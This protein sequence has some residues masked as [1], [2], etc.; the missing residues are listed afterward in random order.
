MQLTHF[1]HSCVLVDGVGDSRLLFDPGT[2]STGFEQLTGLDGVLVTHSHADHL[3][4]ARWPA[5][6]AANP[7]CAVLADSAGAAALIDAGHR[8]QAPA[9]GTHVVAGASIEVLP[10]AHETIHPEVPNPPNN[11]YLVDGRLLH[12]GDSF[13]VPSDAV[14]VLLLPVGGPWLKLADAVDYLRAVA[15]RV[16]VPIHQAGLAPAHQRLHHDLLA[17]L[18]PPGTDVLVPELGVPLTV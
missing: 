8:A 10:H 7:D 11:G 13:L 16:A 5:L 1:G 4:L 6:V 18:A 2:L 14:S 12:P 17:R 15:P 3:D 9:A